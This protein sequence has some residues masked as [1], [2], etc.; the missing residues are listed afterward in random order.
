MSSDTK[1][2]RLIEER[3]VRRRPRARFAGWRLLTRGG[4]GKPFR[5]L[6]SPKYPDPVRP[7]LEPSTGLRRQIV[8]EPFPRRLSRK[9]GW[10]EAG[11]LH[12]HSGIW[13]VTR[14]ARPGA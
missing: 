13:G 8:G 3:L 6:S 9:V 5:G 14:S 11:V 2:R 10:P 12:R 7:T 1:A 4:P